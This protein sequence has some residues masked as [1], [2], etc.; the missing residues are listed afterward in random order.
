MTWH[1]RR[2]LANL[3]IFGVDVY[4]RARKSGIEL[5]TSRGNGQRLWDRE[6]LI[7]GRNIPME[8]GGGGK[9]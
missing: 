8:A 1:R 2:N 9:K 6:E 3:T 7:E 4:E 5:T